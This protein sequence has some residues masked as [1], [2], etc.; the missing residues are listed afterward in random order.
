MVLRLELW[1][2]ALLLYLELWVLQAKEFAAVIESFLS[3]AQG[4]KRNCK[5]RVT[6][7]SLEMV[8]IDLIDSNTLNIVLLY[9]STL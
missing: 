9:L 1:R 6:A 7:I 8:M 5:N 3:A 4:N 2:A